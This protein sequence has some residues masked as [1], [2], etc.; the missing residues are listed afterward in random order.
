MEA[1]ASAGRA[2][3]SR[4]SALPVLAGLRLEVQGDQ[5]HLAGTDLDLTIQVETTVTGQAD[6]I[7]VVPAR[8]IAD[9][10]A[11]SMSHFPAR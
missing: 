4:G 5:L 9:I 3:A 2:V 6:G 1:L 11:I 10:S 8:L 7:A